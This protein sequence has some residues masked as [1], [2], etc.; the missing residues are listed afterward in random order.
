MKQEKV[1]K[2]LVKSAT[3]ISLSTFLSR[4]SGL[5]RDMVSA[6]VFGLSK[7]WDAFVYAFMIPN[8]LRRLVGE[9]ALSSAFIPIYTEVLNQKGKEEADRV[10][11]IV[12]SLL[13]TVL[14]IF[15]F[16]IHWII[17]ALLH[18]FVFSE[19][20]TLA[21]QLLLILFPYIFFL[22]SVALFMGILNCHKRFF[23]TSFTPVLLNLIWIVTV[24]FF[25]SQIERSAEEKISILAWG[26]LF[27]GFAQVL[28]NFIPLLKLGFYPRFIFNLRHPALVK[29]INL[30]APAALGFSITQINIFV[31]L[32][33]AMFLGDGANSALWYGNR[34]M[35]FPLGVF[36]IAM[37]TALLP[38]ISHQVAKNNIE[39]LKNTL[40]FS[41]RS[42]F[43]V[44]IP[45]SVG[46]IVL[47]EPIIRICFERGQFDAYATGRTALTLLCYCFGLFAYSGIKLV[48]S[49]F[50]SLQDTKTPVKVGALC[51]ILNIVFNIILMQFLREAGLA[52]ATALSSTINFILLAWLLRNKIGSFEE[53]K[54][55]FSFIRIV[56]ISIIMGLFTHYF[57]INF[58]FQIFNFSSLNLFIQIV[59]TICLSC[60]VYVILGMLFRVSEMKK[61]V[62]NCKDSLGNIIKTRD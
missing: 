2:S 12:F 30:M 52:L 9:G 37:G 27:A 16:I 10:A 31:D 28:F 32:S 4:I 15:L 5:M 19:K 53:S 51:M 54:V 57:F 35:Q 33:L 58:T 7:V 8:L 24:I 46:L 1:K 45:A 25:C 43:L 48:V 55:I 42:V 18:Y 38:T 44:I 39:G 23:V 22:A 60:I 14:G 56:V 49:A 34:L 36:G 29:I 26:V 21:L 13:I 47:R 50:Y 17:K 40:S 59:I 6:Q 61:M 11:N 62:E 41:L 20:I 3:I